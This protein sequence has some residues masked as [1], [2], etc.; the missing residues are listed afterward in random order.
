M[1]FTNSIYALISTAS[2]HSP[3]LKWLFLVLPIILVCPGIGTENSPNLTVDFTALARIPRELVPS[4]IVATFIR[5]TFLQNLVIDSNGD[6]IVNSVFDGRIWRVSRHGTTELVGQVPGQAFSVAEAPET[7]FIVVGVKL[8]GVV[9]VFHIL[10]S[11]EVKTLMDIEGAVFPNGLERLY[12]GRYLFADSVRGIVWEVNYWK[13]SF[14]VFLQHDLLTPIP[15]NWEP[16]ANGV[17]IFH[18]KLYISNSNRRLLLSV[19]LYDSKAIADTLEIVKE[20]IFAD[21]FDFDEA[22][23]M[24]ITTHPMDVVQRFT[25]NGTISIIAGPDQG[26]R[27]NTGCRF[28]RRPGDEKS[29]YVVADGGIFN[30]TSG[31]LQPAPV[32]RLEIDTKGASGGEKVVASCVEKKW[33]HE[34]H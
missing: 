22:G 31:G 19:Q 7:G 30:P 3:S 33:L 26:V 24:Y 16:G 17:R 10:E 20:E 21:D 2:G 9:A 34:E 4:T 18:D 27:G 11:G 23:N 8:D 32:V 29:L 5:M 1:R 25:P 14:G 6:V 12:N 28:G 15:G 13:K